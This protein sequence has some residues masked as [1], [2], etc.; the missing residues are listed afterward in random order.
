MMTPD[1]FLS[2]P[3]YFEH[4]FVPLQKLQLPVKPLHRGTC[5]KLQKAF[6]GELFEG[7]R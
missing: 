3:Y 2:F 4:V 5:E 6:F 7:K 1:Q